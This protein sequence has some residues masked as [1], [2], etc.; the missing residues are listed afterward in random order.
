MRIRLIGE[1]HTLHEDGDVLTI[2]DEATVAAG[3][4]GTITFARAMALLE[5]HKAEFLRE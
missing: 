5:S 2:A 3:A 4:E 1:N